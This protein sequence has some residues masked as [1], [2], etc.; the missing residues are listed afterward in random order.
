LQGQNI[1]ALVIGWLDEP[2][3][4]ARAARALSDWTQ[5]DLVKAADVALTTLKQFEKGHLTLD[6]GSNPPA[7]AKN[8][9]G[10]T[11]D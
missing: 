2:V 9:R 3:Q 5:P 10:K 1:V 6:G 8:Y 4:Q 11:T 7:T